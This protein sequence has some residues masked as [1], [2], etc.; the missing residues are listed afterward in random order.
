MQFNTF[1]PREGFVAVLIDNSTRFAHDIMGNDFALAFEILDSR[2]PAVRLSEYR[3][4]VGNILIVQSSLI[5]CVG[6][7]IY[8]YIQIL[9]PFDSAYSIISGLMSGFIRSFR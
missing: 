9:S 6:F 5:L 1:T 3:I 4:K 8:R 2:E 7:M